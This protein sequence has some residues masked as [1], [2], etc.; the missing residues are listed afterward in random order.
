MGVGGSQLGQGCEL[1]VKR[2][3]SLERK[4]CQMWMGGS[5]RTKRTDVCARV[6]FY[7]STQLASAA[8]SF[9]HLPSEPSDEA[10]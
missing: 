8:H 3:L 5:H 10:A 4:L 1:V 9:L 7:I 2:H 6:S